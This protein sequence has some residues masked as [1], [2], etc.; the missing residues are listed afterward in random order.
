[1]LNSMKELAFQWKTEAGAA[2]QRARKEG[3]RRGNLG[4]GSNKNK[5]KQ[6]NK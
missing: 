3:E 6:E 1:M 5:E 4:W 2:F